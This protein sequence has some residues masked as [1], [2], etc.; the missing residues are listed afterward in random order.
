[1]QNLIDFFYLKKVTVYKK[2]KFNI[3]DFLLLL[4]TN[5]HKAMGTNVLLI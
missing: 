2:E 5:M 4:M 3:S 1:M